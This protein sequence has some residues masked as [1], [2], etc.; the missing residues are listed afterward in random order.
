[1]H[2]IYSLRIVLWGYVFWVS[3]ALSII[4]C[5]SILPQTQWGPHD[6]RLSKPFTVDTPEK[7]WIV[8]TFTCINHLISTFAGGIVDPWITNQVQN[9]KVQ[10]IQW[11]N[12]E[13]SVA[14][15]VYWVAGWI[16]YLL[17]LM[18]SLARMDFMVIGIASDLLSKQLSLRVHLKNKTGNGFLEEGIHE[19]SVN[20]DNLV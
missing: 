19:D 6:L 14:L 1:M 2:P 16:D 12:F 20:G 15:G 3:T 7:W 4:I 13:T 5:L 10:K 18:I 9:S 17:F 8:A 11:S